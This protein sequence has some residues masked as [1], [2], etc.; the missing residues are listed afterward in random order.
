VRITYRLAFDDYYDASQEQ[1]AKARQVRQGAILAI[2][3]L[4]FGA[5]IRTGNTR[6][7]HVYLALALLLVVALPLAKWLSKR[8]F[9]NPYER[10]AT[11]RSDN[12]LTV[13][14]SED[15]I[16]GSDST[17]RE[18]WLHFSKYSESNDAFILYQVDSVHVILPKRS[19]DIN[20]LDSFRRLIKGKLAR[21]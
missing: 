10:G 8:S 5:W 4:L 12:E 11:K 7:G 19:F 17:N 2:A 14:I 9:K 13:E 21:F 6:V 20:G 18:E 16:Q 3:V 15:G 1:N